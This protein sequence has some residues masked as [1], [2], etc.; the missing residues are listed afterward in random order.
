MPKP[1]PTQ[2]IRH[3]IGLTRDMREMVEGVVGAYQFNRV[4]TPIVAA[5]SDVS[6]LFFVG[7]LLAAWK[8]IDKETWDAM[9]GG[10]TKTVDELLEALRASWDAGEKAWDLGAYIIPGGSKD[11]FWDAFF[12]RDTTAPN[13]ERAAAMTD[14]YTNQSGSPSNPEHRGYGG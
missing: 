8:V 7:G 2:V 4:S 6:F 13:P 11:D 3:E 1:K 14:I 12:G 10:A 5:L 9:T